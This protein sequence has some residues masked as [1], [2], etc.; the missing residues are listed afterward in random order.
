MIDDDEQE[1]RPTGERSI[2]F[3][4]IDFTPITC[5]GRLGE[6]SIRAEGEEREPDAASRG[7]YSH[8]CVVGIHDLIDVSPSVPVPRDDVPT[9]ATG[10][11]GPLKSLLKTLSAVNVNTDR[12]VSLHSLQQGHT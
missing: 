9:D 1:N 12:D 8:R 2:P 11:F 3:I 6:S 7:T 4:L 5:F 10:E